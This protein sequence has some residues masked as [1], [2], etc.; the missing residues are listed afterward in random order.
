MSGQLSSMCYLS[1]KMVKSQSSFL[2]VPQVHCI[3][4]TYYMKWDSANS[5][6][7]NKRTRGVLGS[8]HLREDLLLRRVHAKYSIKVKCLCSLLSCITICYIHFFLD[9]LCLHTWWQTKRLFLYICW[10]ASHSY[11]HVSASS[12]FFSRFL[13]FLKEI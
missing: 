3:L 11:L 7:V 2:L 6:K 8:Y 5:L 12:K 9:C 1:R 10:T 13:H 4:Y